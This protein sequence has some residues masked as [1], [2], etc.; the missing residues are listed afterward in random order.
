MTVPAASIGAP[1]MHVVKGGKIQRL[2]ARIAR[3]LAEFRRLS[4]KPDYEEQARAIVLIVEQERLAE[5]HEWRERRSQSGLK[6]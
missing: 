1:K 3:Q 5:I 6:D 4:A 2:Q